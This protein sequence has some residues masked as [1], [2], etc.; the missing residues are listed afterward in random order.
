MR[1][2]RHIQEA[3][4]THHILIYTEPKYYHIIKPDKM[5]YHSKLV[6]FVPFSWLLRAYK[7]CLLIPIPLSSFS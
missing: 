5:I 1:V 4:I 3:K 7:S 6:D 2:V